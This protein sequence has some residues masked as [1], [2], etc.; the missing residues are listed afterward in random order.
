MNILGL[1]MGNFQGRNPIRDVD[2]RSGTGLKASQVERLTC[3]LQ[4]S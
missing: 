4:N 2:H 1:K 3:T